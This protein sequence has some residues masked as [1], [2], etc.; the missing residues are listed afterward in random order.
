MRPIRTAGWTWRAATASPSAGWGTTRTPHF[1]SIQCGID[2]S[3][4]PTLHP[5][6]REELRQFLTR[7]H[8]ERVP[9]GLNTSVVQWQNWTFA[10][11]TSTSGNVQ[12]VPTAP[13]PIP[14][15]KYTGFFQW[16]KQPVRLAVY[17][18]TDPGQIQS[19]FS[20]KPGLDYTMP[21]YMALEQGF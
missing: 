10:S 5:A 18:A 13:L 12:N 16:Q 1:D 7:N 8:R 21:Y 4:K 19:A 3:L 14:L 17:S 20:E 9:P 2:P 15:R 11:P 6:I